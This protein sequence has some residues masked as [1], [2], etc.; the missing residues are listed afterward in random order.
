MRLLKSGALY[1]ACVFGAGFALGPLRILWVVPRF[2]VRTAEL[3]EMP[4]MLAVIVAAARWAVR[5]LAVPP[6]AATRV[7]MGCVALALL[8]AAGGGSC[9]GTCCRMS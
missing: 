6:E 5:R 2:G 4:I 7:G 9:S 1:F 3:M 8:L